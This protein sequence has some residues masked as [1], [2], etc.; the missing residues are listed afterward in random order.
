MITSLALLRSWVKT[1]KY[2]LTGWQSKNSQSSK[3]TLTFSQL[4]S[5]YDKH[6]FVGFCFCFLVLPGILA[7]KED[8]IS[9][10][11]MVGDWSNEKEFKQIIARCSVKAMRAF[12]NEPYI[13][14][15]LQGAVEEM[16]E[17]GYFKMTK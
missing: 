13:K 2:F 9:Q 1:Q 10:E 6:S 15:V 8:A 17:R 12:K 14:E 11:D 4:L 16:V 3:L 5:D 7:P